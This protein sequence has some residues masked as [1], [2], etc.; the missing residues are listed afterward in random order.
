MG[1]GYGKLTR[2]V[3]DKSGMMGF[4]VTAECGLG[5]AI[6]HRSPCVQKRGEHIAGDDKEAMPIA[7]RRNKGGIK[8]PPSPG[9]AGR[10]DL[11]SQ[12]GERFDSRFSD[13]LN[14][15]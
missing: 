8:T 1:D 7:E 2:I 10:L 14:L 13:C 5:R 3:C 15:Y 9:D 4:R 12:S 6:A 11:P